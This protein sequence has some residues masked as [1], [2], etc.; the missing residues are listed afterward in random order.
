MPLS[1]SYAEC[2]S[3]PTED[4]SRPAEQ[5]GCRE[6]GAGCCGGSLVLGRVV[7]DSPPCVCSA[8]HRAHTHT[9]LFSV[10]DNRRTS[11]RTR[12]LRE[13]PVPDHPSEHTRGNL[14]DTRHHRHRADQGRAWTRHPSHNQLP[15]ASW[16]S[17]CKKGREGELVLAPMCVLCV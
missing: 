5:A 1:S 12:H 10:S 3:R 6:L 9:P 13:E 11:S 14:P 4:R 2:C 7:P 17:N 15:G 16:Q 8:G